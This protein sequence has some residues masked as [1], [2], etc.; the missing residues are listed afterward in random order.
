[1]L[2]KNHILFGFLFSTILYFL[3]PLTILEA[4]IIFLSSFLIDFDHYL[5]Y[6]YRKKRL[7]LKN[8]LRYFYNEGKK[9]KKIM[10]IKNQY[11]RNIFI[12]H[13]VETWIP[14]A[15]ISIYFPIFWFVLIGI[16]IH[17]FLDYIIILRLKD[18]WY[19][20]FSIILTHSMNKNKREL[21]N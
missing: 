4:T 17:I 18:P 7:S 16:G 20:K 12:F 1:M 5:L 8:S 14:L 13:G 15:I 10:P 9:W 19:S 11:K 21:P 6:V 2:P 3:L